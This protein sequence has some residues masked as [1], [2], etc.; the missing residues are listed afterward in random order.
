MALLVVVALPV[1]SVIAYETTSNALQDCKEQVQK[2]K[3]S[4]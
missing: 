1:M 2:L 3:Q 4:I